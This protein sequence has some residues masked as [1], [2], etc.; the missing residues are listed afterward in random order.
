ME[1]PVGSLQP[2][3]SLSPSPGKAQSALHCYNFIISRTSW[4]SNQ[5]KALSITMLLQVTEARQSW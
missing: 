3:T 5:T 2:L 1:S 4:E